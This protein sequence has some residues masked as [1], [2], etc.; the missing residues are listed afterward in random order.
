MQSCNSN[1]FSFC[2]TACWRKLLYPSCFSSLHFLLGIDRHSSR[3]SASL[4]CEWPTS[5][6]RICCL[7]AGR[8]RNLRQVLE[9]IW[10]EVIFFTLVAT[11]K[12]SLFDPEQVH[13]T[14]GPVVSIVSK[15]TN[16]DL[17]VSNQL[18][19]T[20]LGLVKLVL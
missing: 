14:S 1:S 19:L 17:E 20:V 18:V 9:D 6:P 15:K 16:V 13:M 7:D 12:P 2:V 11:G 8:R 3:F 10:P 4:D 5:F